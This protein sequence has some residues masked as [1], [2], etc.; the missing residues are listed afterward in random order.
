M[1][2]IETALSFFGIAILL[3]LSPGPDNV[4]VLLHSALHGRMAGW[5]VVL[6]L[7]TGLLA[8]TIAVALGVAALFAASDTA[9]TVLKIAG[10][11]YLTML[12]M[13]AFRTP[14]GLQAG[15]HATSQSLSPW[16]GYAR[17]VLM[18]LSN[19]KIVVFFLAFLPQFARP[20]NGNLPLQLM[21]LGLI[22]ILATLLTFGVIA[23]FAGTFGSYLRHSPRV[24]RY[25]HR[26][27][28]LVFLGLALRLVLTDR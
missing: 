11:A 21:I 12:A 26:T 1:P 3:G 19:P 27:A 24:Q 6:G 13:Q 17:G 8:H 14:V 23:C 25:L 22:F 7:C 15:D 9:F 5:V 2:T 4:F 10:A 28:G 20:E 16:R 18:N